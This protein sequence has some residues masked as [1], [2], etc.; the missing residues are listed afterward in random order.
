M[1]LLTAL[2]LFGQTLTIPVDVPYGNDYAN[3]PVE[4]TIPGFPSGLGTLDEVH[5]N[6]TTHA[7][8]DGA[9]EN[10]TPFACCAYLGR[11]ICGGGL[12]VPPNRVNLKLYDRDGV[13]L[14]ENP[15]EC[16]DVSAPLDAYDGTDD[17]SGPSGTV[18]HQD[19]EVL[20]INAAVVDGV[21]ALPFHRSVVTLKYE[22]LT[23]MGSGS[24]CGG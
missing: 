17:F 19:D 12:V 10:Q 11:D 4:F 23:Y 16:A 15:I 24:T 7:N 5:V 14:G 18:L 3:P 22:R 20:L 8:L 21:H 13:L 1:L 9:V 2:A 6:I